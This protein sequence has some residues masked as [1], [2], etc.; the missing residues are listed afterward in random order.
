VRSGPWKLHFPHAYRSLA[1]KPGQDGLPG[2]YQQ[3]KCG[4]E[5]YN[6]DD[7]IGESQDV[8]AEHPQVVERL[9][10]LADSIRSQLGDSLTKRAGSEIRPAGKLEPLQLQAQS[11]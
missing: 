5:L 4:L 11:R 9:Q 7:D 3:L 6:L 10:K 2:P 1:G 8:A